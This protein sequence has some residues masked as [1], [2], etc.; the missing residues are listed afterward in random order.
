MKKTAN[1]IKTKKTQN[2]SRK[3]VKL[4]CTENNIVL[5]AELLNHT[6]A[7]MLT[8]LVDRKIRINLRYNT[9]NKNYVGI[10]GKLEFTSNG[11]EK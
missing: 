2:S 9:A 5:E 3:K 8:C 7:Y 6:P 11:P 10:V 4:K 1:N